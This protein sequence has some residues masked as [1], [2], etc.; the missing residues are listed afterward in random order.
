M[1]SPNYDQLHIDHSK[2]IGDA[3]AAAATN[4]KVWTSA[5]RDIHLNEACRR[6]ML[7]YKV[8][9]DREGDASDGWDFFRSLV[10]SEGQAMSSNAIALSSYT[11]GVFKI[12]SVLNGTT[13]VKP[14]PQ[15]WVDD[16]ASV[17]Y[18][19]WYDGASTNQYYHI[20]AGSLT[21]I[22]GGATD[23]IT[24]RYVKNWT[25]LTA[26]NA[27]DIPIPSKY[28]HQV[29]DVAYGIVMEERANPTS[30]QL[31][32]IKVGVVE[33]EIAESGALRNA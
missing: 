8:K 16:I 30:Q 6:L 1:A 12:I 10:N 25:A 2:R 18:M 13:V 21:N 11:G 32:A 3:V 33:K 31:A 29:L 4:G 5:Q 9:I 26:G 23:T 27:T 17:S 19:P 28:F 15:E 22:G 24:L 20:Q 14:I 7:K